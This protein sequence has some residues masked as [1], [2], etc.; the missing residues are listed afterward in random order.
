MADYLPDM[1]N[2]ACPLNAPPF[3]TQHPKLWFVILEMNFMVNNIVSSGIKFMHTAC[4]LPVDS[5]HKVADVISTLQDSDTPYQTLKESIIRAHLEELLCRE[6]HLGDDELPSD[7]LRRMNNLLQ[8]NDP[9]FDQQLFRQ[10]FYGKLP[11]RIQSALITVKDKLNVED[12]A[13]LADEFMKNSLESSRSKNASDEI[14]EIVDMLANLT[15]RISMLETVSS[16]IHRRTRSRKN[17]ITKNHCY[18]H[19]VFREYA[20]KCRGPCNYPETENK[21]AQGKQ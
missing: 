19:R 4:L 14:S 2:S 3:F 10:I 12:T 17:S 9:S 18:Y 16:P 20:L 7:L 5:L 8:D 13:L 11:H 1:N 6:D 21:R 15:T